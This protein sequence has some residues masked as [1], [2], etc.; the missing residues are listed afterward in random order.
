MLT[1]RRILVPTDFS[2]YADRA[3]AH[4]CMLAE[5]FGAELTLLHVVEEPAFPAFYEAASA[6]YGAPPDMTEEA[7]T[8]LQ[9]LIEEVDVG[10]ACPVSY[11]V[12]SGQAAANIVACAEETDADLIVL[13]SHGLTGIKHLLMGS[14]AEKVVRR[15]PCP[16]FV[17]KAFGKALLP[18]RASTGSAD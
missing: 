6:V 4:A 17:L 14:V 11:R 18:D 3:L 13:A 12:R 16:V 10:P 8:A 1:I 2:D 5:T 15:S 7:Q 9:E